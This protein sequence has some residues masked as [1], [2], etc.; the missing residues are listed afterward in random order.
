[1][2][3]LKVPKPKAIIFDL[4]GTVVETSF[5][6]EVLIPYI[7]TNIKSYVEQKWTEKELTK[8]VERLRAQ[9]QKDESAPKIAGTDAEVAEQQQ[10]V[11]DYVLFCLDDKKE[12]RALSLFRFHI[13]F[14]GYDNNQIQTPVYSDVAIQIKKW[15][16]DLHIKLYVVSNGW[17]DATKKF[18]SNTN[19]GDLNLLIDNHFDTSLGPLTDKESYQKILAKIGEQ[20]EDVI[21]LTKSP[22]EAKAAKEVGIT[23]ILVLTHRRNIQKLDESDKQMT[24]I[25]SFNELEFE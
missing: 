6:D 5:I 8:D 2:A 13:W 20:P 22:E 1:M 16:C 24:I 7:K 14:D 19:H 12:S 15:K 10:S 4:S 11:V 9:S 18:M 21:F 3:N 17:V 23:P 25:R